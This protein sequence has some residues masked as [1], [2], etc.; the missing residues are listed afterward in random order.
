MV[1][2]EAAPSRGTEWT[3]PVDLALH[4]FADLTSVVHVRGHKVLV[5]LLN[6]EVLNVPADTSCDDCDPQSPEAACPV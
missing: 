3:I 6:G 2:L 5:G 1:F 4:E